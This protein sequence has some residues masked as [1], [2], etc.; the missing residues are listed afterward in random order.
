VSAWLFQTKIFQ[1]KERTVVH[2]G[3]IPHPPLVSQKLGL[4]GRLL[5]G[6]RGCSKQKIFQE[7]VRTVI[8]NGEISH[9]PLVSQKLCLGS[10][11]LLGQ[12]GCSK[13]KSFKNRSGL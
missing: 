13:Q 10:R 12:R 7:Q 9:P 2:N 5:L 6:Q 11:L 1:E 3:E 8:H 4:G